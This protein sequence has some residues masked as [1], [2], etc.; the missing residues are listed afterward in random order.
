MGRYV[1][2][3]ARELAA[4]GRLPVVFA[5]EGRTTLPAGNGLSSSAALE[6]EAAIAL[7]AVAET[8]STCFRKE[9]S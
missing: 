2:A 1:A 8:V 9:P 7:C 4:P 3:V 6:A 5:G